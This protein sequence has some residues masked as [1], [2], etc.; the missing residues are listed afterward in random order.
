MLMLSGGLSP[1]F[2]GPGPALTSGP[3][4]A[5]KGEPKG[6]RLWVRFKGFAELSD[7]SVPMVPFFSSLCDSAR[8][9]V[10]I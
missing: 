7:A 6:G 2:F 1:L 3:V 5:L 8:G 9:G 10:M 4:A